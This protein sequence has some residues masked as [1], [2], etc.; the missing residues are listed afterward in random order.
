[1][2]TINLKMIKKL[3]ALVCVF[4]ML[5]GITVSAQTEQADIS[6]KEQTAIELLEILGIYDGVDSLAGRDAFVRRDVFALLATRMMGLDDTVYQGEAYF[7]DVDEKSFAYNAVNT[8]AK[9]QVIRGSGDGKFVPERDIT[10]EEATVMVLRMMG[11]SQL[12]DAQG[13]GQWRTLAQKHNLYSGVEFA[14]DS[15]LQV[16]Y[17]TILIYNV[18][19]SDFPQVVS[20]SKDGQSQ[21][22]IQKGEDLLSEV[23][24]VYEIK[25]LIDSNGHTATNVVSVGN[26]GSVEINGTEF[27]VGNTDA[28]LYVGYYVT[29]YYHTD[30]Y[31]VNT[32]LCIDVESRNKVIQFD[33]ND[34]TYRDFNY[35]VDV[36]G[37]EVTYKISRG[38]NQIYNGKAIYYDASKMD[39]TYG[40]VTLIDNNND[41]VYDTVLIEEVRNLIVASYGTVSNIIQ[42]KYDNPPLDL[43][44]HDEAMYTIHTKEG[45]PYK[46]TSLKEW[47]VL[48][49]QESADGMYFDITVCTDTVTGTVEQIYTENGATI[50]TIG[51]KEYEV[52][53]AFENNT[54]YYDVTLNYSG[55]F[56]LDMYGKIV[57]ANGGIEQMKWGYLLETQTKPGFST[58]FSVKMLTKDSGKIQIIEAAESYTVDGVKYPNA[59]NQAPTI[60][61]LDDETRIV[62]WKLGYYDLPSNQVVRYSLDK[63]GKL[64]TLQTSAGG[65]FSVIHPAGV[66]GD[67]EQ[68]YADG[69]SANAFDNYVAMD[70]DTV[71]FQ[72]PNMSRANDHESDEEF[73]AVKPLSSFKNGDWYWT[74]AFGY[75]ADDVTAAAVVVQRFYASATNPTGTYM[76]V[77]DVRTGLNKDGEVVDKIVGY[78]TAKAEIEILTRENSKVIDYDWQLNSEEKWVRVSV[79]KS[80]SEIEP[81]DLFAMV[82]YPDGTLQNAVVVCDSDHLFPTSWREQNASA[83]FS[84]AY[85]QANFARVGYAKDIKG[86]TLQVLEPG[87]SREDVYSEVRRVY[88]TSSAAVLIVDE[89]TKKVTPGSLSDIL[90]LDQSG[91]SAK[92]VIYGGQSVP[93]LIVSYQ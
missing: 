32:L 59:T 19:I 34:A 91:V 24:D 63:N 25:G 79:T 36:N 72:I 53:P 88:N 7:T 12:M 66:N 61:D 51:D 56:F 13:P 71:I 81:G 67:G 16:K 90:T 60:D 9:M 21:Y 70:S 87:W 93:R 39:P 29:G 77:T 86:K 18:L 50:L 62:S 85:D 82:L 27:Q 73:Y 68:Y 40:R 10:V 47:D 89:T 75:N 65:A 35:K 14:K 20:I 48:S 15:R 69:F 17:L 33:G 52:A 41:S 57:A 44:A 26:A 92:V 42:S 74:R 37:K 8:L 80:L 2:V 43:K 49:V 54:A 31:G 1:M 23:F 84:I 4:V 58:K 28:Q 3:V 5:F 78:N 6:K 11:Y 45:K 55:T 83:Y 30:E 38:L 46:L 22:E 64:K 76:V